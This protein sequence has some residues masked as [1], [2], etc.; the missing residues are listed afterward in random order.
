MSLNEEL[1]K[2]FDKNISNNINLSNYSWFNLGGPAE[3]FFKPSN[4]RQLIEFLKINKK[5]KLNIT[6][7]GAGSNTL[8]RDNGIKGVVIK[9]GSSFS[10]IKLKDK[11]TIKAGAATLD[12]KIS[13]FA[14]ENCIGGLEFLSCIPG[15]IGGS[16]I[17]NSGCY[18]S[19]I[20]K[21]LVSINVV[22][23]KS[24]LEKEIKFEEIEFYYR[25]NNL[26]KNLIITSVTLKGKIESRSII[27]QNQ[28]NLIEKKKLTQPSQ[29][30]T[31]GS[32][33]KNLSS[34]KKAWQII[35][36]TGCSEFK[37]GDAEISKKHCN[38][39][40]NNGEAKSSDIEKLINKVKKTVNDKT[41]IDLELEI[42]IIGE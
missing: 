20:S 4:E 3:Y 38:F 32:T 33:F 26:S 22:D 34:E 18:G 37:E 7:L 6:I 41:G 10:E 15:S 9:L 17:M 11:L 42:K 21:V 30:K 1:K 36:E 13:N 14:K 16:V 27:E 8:I 31:C 28:R 25:G 24:C 39:F 35:K 29:I 19:D 40:V 23:V 12:R 5:N 2:K